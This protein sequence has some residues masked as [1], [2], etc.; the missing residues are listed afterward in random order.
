M[1][2]W[3]AL[4]G[5]CRLVRCKCFMIARRYYRLCERHESAKTRR[6]K[7]WAWRSDRRCSRSKHTVKDI[8]TQPIRDNIT[9]RQRNLLH[10]VTYRYRIHANCT[11][12][13]FTRVILFILFFSLFYIISTILGRN[14]DE[15]HARERGRKRQADADIQPDAHIDTQPNTHCLLDT[16]VFR[17]TSTRR[18]GDGRAI[19]NK[20]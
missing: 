11:Y 7:H 19:V 10:S 13:T 2:L 14:L 20:R 6:S 1:H 5:K 8:L 18:F 12:R 3:P 16:L 17:L 4:V 9:W 15:E